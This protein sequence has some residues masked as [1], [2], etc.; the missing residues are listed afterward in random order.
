MF[1]T[2]AIVG[3]ALAGIMAI[4]QSK[5]DIRINQIQIIG[6]HNSYHVGLTPGIKAFLLKNNPKAE[7]GLDYEH[8]PIPT[9][10]DSGIRQLEIDIY[11][12]SKGGLYSHPAAAKAIQEMGYPAEPYNT[13]G[14]MDKPGFKVM[15]VQDIDQHSSCITL[16]I[17]L[18][19]V[20]TWSNAHPRHVPIFILLEGKYGKPMNIPGAV[21]TEQFTPAVFDELDAEIRSIVP[22]NK[23][24]TPDQVR[25][26]YATMPEAIAHGGWPTLASSRGKLVFLMDNRALTPIYVEGHPADKGRVIFPNGVVGDPETAFTEENFGAEDRLDD[27]AKQGVLVRTRSDADTEQARTN[28]TSLRDKDFR[29]GAQIIST[30]YYSIEPAKWPG[31]FVVEFPNNVVARCNP[32]NAPKGCPAG[33]LEK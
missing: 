27:L 13:D 10:L 11:A 6:S 7:H 20:L 3:C 24:I 26:S 31:H 17:C 15:H 29:S 22:A 33:D 8:K 18:E 23:L 30:D 5:N 12:D 9:Q 4:A 21:T 1:R 28:D 16:R 19:Q 14:A 32:I 2:L 25:G